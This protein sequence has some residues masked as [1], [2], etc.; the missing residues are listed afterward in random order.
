MKYAFRKFLLLFDHRKNARS[1]GVLRLKEIKLRFKN[2]QG[3]RLAVRLGYSLF[4]E[5]LRYTVDP[6]LQNAI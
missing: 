2:V 5:I 4:D 3:E 1:K 6:F